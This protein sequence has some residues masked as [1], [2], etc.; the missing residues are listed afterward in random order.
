MPR[1]SA[2]KNFLSDAK[3]LGQLVLSF[4]NWTFKNSFIFVRMNFL[5]EIDWVENLA[6]KSQ[7]TFISRRF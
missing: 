7:V 2:D 4:Q 3:S 6:R 5:T 1:S